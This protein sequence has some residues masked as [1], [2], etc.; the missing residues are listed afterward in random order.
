MFRRIAE[1]LEIKGDNPFRI[2]AYLRAADNVENLK[3]GIEE[4]AS[5]DRL[6]EIPGIGSD[7]ADKIGEI[8]KTG[9]CRQYQ[10]L[11]KLIPEGVLE[12][13]EIPTVGPKTAKLLYDR[14]K[15]KSVV[16][17]KKAAQQGRL[18][19]F[20]GIKEKTIENI[21]KGIE[22]VNKGKER[23]DLLTA[24]A[25]AGSVVA[26][27]KAVKEAQRIETAGSL[28]RMKETVRDIDIL[29]VS[30]SAKKIS[31]AFVSLPQ[32]KQ[33]LAQG[34][35]KSSILTKDNV[36]VDLRVLDSKS[37]GAALLYFTGS[38]DHN[39]KL[40]QL[41]IKKGLKINEYGVFNKKEECLA[42]RTEKEVYRALGLDLIAP[43]MREDAGEIEASL[44]HELPRLLEIK[45]IRGDFHVHTSYSDGKGTVEEMAREALR[46]GYDYVCLTDH[47]QT[48]KVARGLDLKRLKEKKREID[49]VN[50][51]LK[52]FTILFGSE[53]EIDSEGNL[54][55]S[56][57]VLSE[58]DVVVAAIHSGFKQS[59]A[60]LTKRIVNACKNKYVHIIAHPTGKLW[61]S[62]GP[63]ELD[64][65]EIFKAAR[66]TNT[67]LEINAHPYRLDLS[68][69]HARFAK[70]SG[71]K[72][73]ISTDSHD[74]GHLSYMKYGVGLARRAWLEG[75]DV[76]NSLR[77]DAL[78]KAIR[79]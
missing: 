21:L 19:G 59:R 50:K 76:L 79:K 65:K 53:V 40:R 7:L 55:Y 72:L 15:I 30:K 16:E 38:K 14:L 2:R 31:R 34:L 52:K 10:E 35:T 73:V 32:V 9:T 71:V 49:K 3:Q 20:P 61:L 56:D 8:I 67:A 25:V 33:V 5:S 4:Y 43:E 63:Y 48:L 1:L 75:K 39:I 77:L 69:V 42:S 27:L 74:V 66:D 24:D 64:F 26:G 41:A 54:D 6:S 60:Q 51:K 45:D 28:R 46:L 17:L 68:D 47:S 23:M 44:K 13:L 57:N 12:I 36:Q 58:F 78:L 62:R 22:L 11:I 37:F 29:V 18:L 70:D